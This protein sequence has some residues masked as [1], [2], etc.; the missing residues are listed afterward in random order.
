[1]LNR[2]GLDH[3]EL[4]GK[5]I[6]CCFEVLNELGN[7]FLETVYKNALSI[8]LQ[9]IGFQVLLE[10]SFDVIFRDQIIGKYIADLIVENLVIIEVKSCNNLL[11]EHQAQLINYLKVSGIRIGLLVNFGHQKMEYRRLSHPAEHIDEEIPFV[12][13]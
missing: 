10:Q 13:S 5:I 1:M 11:P 4:T 8:S 9:Q 6:G 2:K 7:G 12:L 3:F